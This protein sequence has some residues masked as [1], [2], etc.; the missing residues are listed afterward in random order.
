MFNGSLQI[1]C[2]CSG[3]H[4]SRVSAWNRITHVCGR[5]TSSFVATYGKAE[6]VFSLVLQPNPVPY[7]RALMLVPK[8]G[9]SSRVGLFL[10]S[11][12]LPPTQPVDFCLW[13]HNELDT[14][15]SISHGQYMSS[16]T[17]RGYSDVRKEKKRHLLASIK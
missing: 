13:L 9:N 2:G 12:G 6:T 17:L 15:K 11:A 10:Q 8:Y 5:R 7:C 14:R 4:S 16:C 3:G 1:D